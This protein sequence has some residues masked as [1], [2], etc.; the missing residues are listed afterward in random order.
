MCA[1]PVA[2]WFLLYLTLVLIVLSLNISQFLSG[3]GERIKKL[4]DVGSLNVFYT[5]GSYFFDFL[6]ENH[7]TL[8]FV[9][10][11]VNLRVFTIPSRPEIYV[12]C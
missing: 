12:F 11:R 7:I 9:F 6:K 3:N 5:L 10:M 1:Q 8:L 4:R 2:Q